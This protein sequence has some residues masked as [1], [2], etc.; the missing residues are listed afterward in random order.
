MRINK[1]AIVISAALAVGCGASAQDQV[2]YA[3]LAQGRTPA[4]FANAGWQ[5]TLLQA[6]IGFGPAYFCAAA[7]A[8]SDLCPSAVAEYA[9]SATIDALS[10]AAQPIGTVHGLTGTVRSYRYDYAITWLPRQG[11]ATPSPGA[12]GGHSAVFQGRAHFAG[13]RR[14]GPSDLHFFAQVD[15]TPKNQGASVGAGANLAVE[16]SQASAALTVGFDPQAI[17]QSVDFEDLA[18]AASPNGEVTVAPDSRA[19]NALVFAMTVGAPPT[20]SWR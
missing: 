20:F 2:D 1:T 5:V 6:R 3:A 11:A 9:D 7:A 16:V 8:D 10:P 18:A 12:P 14:T 17:W 15:V 13:P 4:S 19:Y